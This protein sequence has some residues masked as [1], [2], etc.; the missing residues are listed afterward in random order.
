MLLLL[1]IFSLYRC[2]AAIVTWTNPQCISNCYKGWWCD[3]DGLSWTYCFTKNQYRTM[4]DELCI[5]D[6]LLG[7]N[8]R[9]YCYTDSSRNWNYCSQKDGYTIYGD[10][11]ATEC[12]Y[13]PR[14]TFFT[15]KIQKDNFKLKYA[16]SPSSKKRTVFSSN[17]QGCKSR[18]GKFRNTK[19]D[20]CYTEKSWKYCDRFAELKEKL[21]QKQCLIYNKKNYRGKRGLNDDR[22]N[23]IE[24]FL[25][26]LVRTQQCKETILQGDAAHPTVN[27]ISVQPPTLPNHNDRYIP[28]RMRARITAAHLTTRTAIPS[29]ITSVMRDMDALSD[30]ERGHILA[31]SFGGPNDELNFVPQSSGLNRRASSTSHWYTFETE[32]R[33]FL[34]SRPSAYVDYTVHIIY[35]DLNTNRRP[36]GFFVRIR[37]YSEGV[38]STDSG[39][40]YFSNNPNGPSLFENDVGFPWPRSNP[41][42]APRLN[43]TP[44]LRSD[45]KRDEPFYSKPLQRN[46]S[47]VLKPLPT[48][49]HSGVRKPGVL[50]P[51]PT[52]PHSGVRKPLPTPPY[53]GVRKPLPTR[54][55]IP[56]T[57]PTRKPIPPT[58]PTRKP[59]P[60]TLPTRK[61]IPPPTFE[62]DEEDDE[63]DESDE[64]DE[65]ED[66]DEYENDDDD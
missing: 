60:P 39:Y 29:S 42:P 50:K 1:I 21:S 15:C 3:A 9:G 25:A 63:S 36:V 20:W 51:L 59:I 18:C 32:I 34:R 8:G 52:P 4:K 12:K 23:D 38:L 37:M 35:G 22:L 30:D 45:L 43:P 13:S 66:D 7:A 46:P 2:L 40:C 53:S 14:V 61:P 64:S 31:A 56:P 49:P 58:L 62:D 19:Y 28:V 11:C 48:P 24:E 54:K 26:N 6:C 27:Y 16:C 10:K 44:N 41:T 17:I 47:K 55:P 65:E 5:T 57:L 33:E